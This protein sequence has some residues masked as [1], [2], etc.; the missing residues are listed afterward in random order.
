MYFFLFPLFSQ[1][2]ISAEGFLCPPQKQSTAFMIEIDG[3]HPNEWGNPSS[4]IP[5]YGS[6]FHPDMKSLDMRLSLEGFP[7]QPWSFHFSILLC[8]V[9]SDAEHHP[10]RPLLSCAEMTAA[11][12]HGNG[13]ITCLHA[14]SERVQWL[15]VTTQGCHQG[16]NKS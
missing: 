10:K 15:T 14:W 7:L 11:K 2:G 9:D 3:W 6:L 5:E 1:I 16:K 8:K 12:M 4:S 13:S